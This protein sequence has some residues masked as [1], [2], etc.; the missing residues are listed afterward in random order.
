MPRDLIDQVAEL[1]E[2][3]AFCF[4]L[5]LEVGVRDDVGQAIPMLDARTHRPRRRTQGA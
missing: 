5:C 3:E 1:K 2:L 4:E